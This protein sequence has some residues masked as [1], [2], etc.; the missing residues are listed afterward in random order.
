MFACLAVLA[1]L[2]MIS[3]LPS[4]AGDKKEGPPG[5]DVPKPG[6]EHKM[7]AGLAGTFKAEV[8]MMDPTGS[9]KSLE[10]KGTMKRSV[11]LDGRYVKEDFAGE[12][13]G[14]KFKGMGLVGYDTNKKKFVGAWMD[15]M[16]T[17]IMTSEGTYDAASKT[18]TSHGVEDAKGMKVKTK[19]VLKI[20]SPDEQHMEM[21]R[22]M[23]DME[24]K[25]MEITFTRVKEMKKEKKAK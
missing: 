1:L 23:G 24:M 8:K 22:T 10:S 21:Y 25:I 15:T 9:G 7:L 5:F 6:P 4:S 2:G 11:I 20:V 18:L 14:Q 3:N 19:D 16:S 17:G 12:F 13:L